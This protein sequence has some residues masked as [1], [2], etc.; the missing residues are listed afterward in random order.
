MSASDLAAQNIQLTDAIISNLTNLALTSISLFDFADGQ[1]TSKRA[2]TADECKTFPGDA[3][4]PL[5]IIWDV[6]DLLAGGALIK[7]VP[8]ASPCYDSWG[9]YDAETC[10]HITEQWTNSS[11]Q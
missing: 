6:F 7:N 3:S 9:D 1:A 10:A 11:F 2:V 8:L 4:W 5:D